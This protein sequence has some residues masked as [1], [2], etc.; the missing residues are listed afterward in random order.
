MLRNAKYRT[1]L[2]LMVFIYMLLLV[3]DRF[4]LRDYARRFVEVFTSSNKIK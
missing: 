3:A 2:T 4:Q 1:G